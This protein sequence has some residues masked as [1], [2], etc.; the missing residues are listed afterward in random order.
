MKIKQGSVSRNVFLLGLV[1]FLNDLSSEMIMLIYRMF[2]KALGGGG[3]IVGFI[4][5]LR[6]GIEYSQ[7]SGK[8]FKIRI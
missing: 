5:G 3:L 6:D 7:S 8:I 2:I 1:S 4:G